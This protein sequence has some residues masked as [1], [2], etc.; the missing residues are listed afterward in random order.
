MVEEMTTKQNASL[1]TKAGLER[2]SLQLDNYSQP[3]KVD[4]VDSYTNQMNEVISIAADKAI[5]VDI[6]ESS[7]IVNEKISLPVIEENMIN[8]DSSI[9]VFKKRSML[10][11]LFSAVV[12]AGCSLLTSVAQADS[13]CVNRD[14]NSTEPKGKAIHLSGSKDSLIAETFN[15]EEDNS[16][17]GLTYFYASS[18]EIPEKEAKFYAFTTRQKGQENVL[19]AD[20]LVWYVSKDKNKDMSVVN[21][22]H[23]DNTDNVKVIATYDCMEQ[24]KI[25][26]ES[27]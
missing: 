10:G 8:T 18:G 12:L 25:N 16:S 17:R 15:L 13:I 2:C 7:D 5:N 1:L 11:K 19:E 3:I 27:K 14:D 4:C 24:S 22:T 9:R 26:N 20:G 23:T 21:F 6:K